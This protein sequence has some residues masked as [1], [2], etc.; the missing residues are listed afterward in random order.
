METWKT[1]QNQPSRILPGKGD[2]NMFTWKG[3]RKNPQSHYQHV[4]Q[5]KASGH[6]THFFPW[7]THRGKLEKE[8]RPHIT[9]LKDMIRARTN[10]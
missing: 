4:Y 7:V 6:H 2:N 5:E 9:S 8:T 1:C 3:C 10:L